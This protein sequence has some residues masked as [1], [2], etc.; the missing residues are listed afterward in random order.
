MRGLGA[1]IGPILDKLAVAPID[2]PKLTSFLQN[3]RN[4]DLMSHFCAA[5][6]TSPDDM[7]FHLTSSGINITVKDV[8]TAYAL[9]KDL[10][11]QDR[12]QL[13]M[14]RGAYCRL[15]SHELARFFYRVAKDRCEAEG[16]TPED[17]F[18]AF[19]DLVTRV[20]A[21]SAVFEQVGHEFATDSEEGEEP[22][23]GGLAEQLAAILSPKERALFKTYVD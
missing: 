9:S 14:R 21:G 10:V 1:F 8:V 7:T 23:V 17:Y 20:F 6:G 15:E 11:V 18:P 19:V 2:D 16:R 5:Q 12:E 13:A 22:S 3:S 4:E